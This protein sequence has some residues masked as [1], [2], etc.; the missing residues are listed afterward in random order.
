[1]LPRLPVVCYFKLQVM[2]EP[3]AQLHQRW[4]KGRGACVC[5]GLG[6]GACGLD[7]AAGWASSL[8]CMHPLRTL[9]HASAIC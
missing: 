8:A 7:C 2:A 3:Y 6:N 5:W 1:M 4:I 9:C